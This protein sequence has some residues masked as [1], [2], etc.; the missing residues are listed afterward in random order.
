MLFNF[1]L[2]LYNKFANKKLVL[3]NNDVE[4]WGIF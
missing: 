3:A 2:K 1:S 4:S